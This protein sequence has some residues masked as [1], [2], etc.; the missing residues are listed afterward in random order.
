MGEVTGVGEGE[1]EES[2]E[3]E[4]E[5]TGVGDGEGEE[6]VEGEGGGTGLSSAPVMVTVKSLV[7]VSMP[8]ETLMRKNSTTVSPSSRGSMAADC[9]V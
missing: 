6:S 8:S 4:G 3:G 5:G 1:G 7:A 9:G 2:V